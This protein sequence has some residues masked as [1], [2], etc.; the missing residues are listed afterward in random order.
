M[1]TLTKTTELSAINTMLSCIS[2]SP[3]NSLDETGL[4]D[5]DIAKSVL[6][7]VTRAVLSVGWKFN[8]EVDYPL[9]RDA[10][11]KIAYPA[12]ALK[13]KPTARY[14]DKGYDVVQRGDFLYN[15]KTRSFVFD[16]DIEVEVVWLFTFEELPEAVR[17]YIVVC[18]SRVFQARQLGSDTQ[19]KFSE[20]DEMKALV[21]L[22]DHEGD[23]ADYNYLTD[24]LSVASVLMR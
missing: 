9:I 12:T 11:G 10:D 6:N 4:V 13:I 17:H 16:A 1:T 21:A 15:L 7:E 24:S 8:R 23:T 18:A 22:K 5:V 19:H 3:I 20:A 14:R 2:E